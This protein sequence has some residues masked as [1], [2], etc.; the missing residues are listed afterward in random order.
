MIKC[1]HKSFFGECELSVSMNDLPSH[2]DHFKIIRRVIIEQW[3]G[4]ITE[5]HKMFAFICAYLQIF[6]WQTV[7]FSWKCSDSAVLATFYSPKFLSPQF[8]SSL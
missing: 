7:I 5:Y 8:D 3:F 2:S 6:A 4:I 1:L